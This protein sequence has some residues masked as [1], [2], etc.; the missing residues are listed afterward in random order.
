MRVHDFLIDQN[1]VSQY[2]NSVIITHVQHM[3]KI[4]INALIHLE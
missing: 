4:K 1:Y 2:L 3:T